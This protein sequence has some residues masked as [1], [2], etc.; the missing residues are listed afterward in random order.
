VAVW[1]GVVIGDC[2]M[3]LVA[4]QFGGGGGDGSG[5]GIW[6]V[7]VKWWWLRPCVMSFL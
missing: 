6:V 1:G 4:V 7:E 5:H 3:V 2:W